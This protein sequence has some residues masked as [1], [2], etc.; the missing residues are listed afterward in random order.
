MIGLHGK[1]GRKHE[2]RAAS[3]EVFF[4]SLRGWSTITQLNILLP[5][6]SFFVFSALTESVTG[7]DE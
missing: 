4:F 2:N 3:G 7:D 6:F 5:V 1:N